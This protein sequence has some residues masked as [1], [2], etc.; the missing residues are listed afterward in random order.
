MMIVIY[1]DSNLLSFMGG[2]L[3]LRFSYLEYKILF[4]VFS[5]IFIL[6]DLYLLKKN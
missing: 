6:T 5:V 4:F 3:N 1:F 2:Q